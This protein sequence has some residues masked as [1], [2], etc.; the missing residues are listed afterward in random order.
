MLTLLT[1]TGSRQPAWNICEKLMLKQTYTGP[2][3]WIIVDDGP[4]AQS[5]TFSKPNWQLEVL[6]PQPYWTP[7]NNTQARNLRYG[8]DIIDDTESVLVIEDDDWYHSKYLETMANDLDKA[9][10]IGHGTARYYHLKNL[11]YKEASGRK[12]CCLNS[13]VIQ[14]EGL[15]IFRQMCKTLITHIDEN[16]WIRSKSKFMYDYKM[17][18]GMKG[19][20]G[21]RG[22]GYYHHAEKFGAVDKSHNIIK[23]WLGDDVFLYDHLLK[24]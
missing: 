8:L 15:K 22:I 14:G 19:L 17:V 11:M 24:P 1:V 21:R 18:V 5:I 4:E 3:R 20:G 12:Y 10:L 6:R 13:T 16:T 7:G 23:S 9:D 2:V